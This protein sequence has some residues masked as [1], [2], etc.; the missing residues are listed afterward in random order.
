MSPHVPFWIGMTLLTLVF[1]VLSANS[2]YWNGVN[3]GY[4]FSREPNNPGYQKAGRIL[5]R[6]A[7]HRW[8]ELKEK[9]SDGKKD[10]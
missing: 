4:G 9:P 2:A 5:R 1:S 8:P 7:S 3:D 6:I 10:V